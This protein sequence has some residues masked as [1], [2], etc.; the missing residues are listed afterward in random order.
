M[1]SRKLYGW[2]RPEPVVAYLNAG[3]ISLKFQDGELRYLQAGGKEIIRRVYF[4]VRDRVFDT[5]MPVF[6]K[7]EVEDNGSSFR[8]SMSAT[9]K[10]ETENADFSWTGEIVGS[11]DGVITFSVD[12]VVNSA[13]K[14]PRVGLNVLYGTESL[15]GQE[16][17][18]LHPDGAVSQSSFPHDVQHSLLEESLRT[19]TYETATEMKVTTEFIGCICQME[20]QR[21]YGDSSFKALSSLTYSYP[22]LQAGLRASQ[23]VR[24]SVENAD[25]LPSRE[26]D[27]Y[28]VTVGSSIFGS[29]VPKLLEIE[30]ATDTPVFFD[31]SAMPY[32]SYSGEVLRWFYN[33]SLH[34]PDD[35]TFVEN[36]SA[37]IDQVRTARKIAPGAQMR[38]N[39]ETA[40]RL[41]PVAF[42][43]PH[44]RPGPDPRNNGLFAAMWA[45]LVWKYATEAGVEELVFKRR[46]GF[47]GA[48]HKLMKPYEGWT[49]HA[50]GV[51]LGV[52]PALQTL[53]LNSEDSRCLLLINASAETITARI[54]PGFLPGSVRM[55]RINADVNPENELA[56]ESVDSAASIKLGALEVAVVAAETARTN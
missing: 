36:P 33:P 49:A 23:T 32:G 42:D 13:F 16:Y 34:Q 7:L 9:C 41:E 40:L 56:W 38:V 35:D 27:K 14:S 19:L 15:C 31:I 51:P 5:A 39:P 3:P 47:W 43:S 52:R 10:N 22:D 18:V 12:G 21:N 28:T 24:I 53:A 25:T 4:A 6:D 26:T 48:I 8:V 1:D 45:A 37:I 20:D 2:D 44:I 50:V 17:E 55:A 54:R 29:H 46:D 30:P 11:E